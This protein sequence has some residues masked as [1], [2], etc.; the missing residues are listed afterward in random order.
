MT[1]PGCGISEEDRK[2]IFK[3][4]EKLNESVKGTGLG[5]YISM[6]ISKKLGGKIYLDENY[7]TGARFVFEHPMRL[8]FG[9]KLIGEEDDSEEAAQI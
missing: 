6:L 5:L 3:R 9:Q 4:Y 7:N 1:D 2:R 8:Q